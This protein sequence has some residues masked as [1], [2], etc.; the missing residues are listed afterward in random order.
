MRLA[1][2]RSVERRLVF[3]PYRNGQLTAKIY[4]FLNT[5]PSRS[6]GYQYFVERP[7]GRQRFPDWMDTYQQAHGLMVKHS[8]PMR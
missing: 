7:T 3:K 5:G 4:D 1:V 2:C 8:V 6:F